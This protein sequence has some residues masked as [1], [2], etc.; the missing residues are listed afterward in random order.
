MRAS[1]S[2]NGTSTGLVSVHLNLNVIVDI[3][4]KRMW[5][6]SLIS[7]FLCSKAWIVMQYVPQ[8]V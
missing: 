2:M 8:C 7:Q 6:T 1:G 3:P 5:S 4:V